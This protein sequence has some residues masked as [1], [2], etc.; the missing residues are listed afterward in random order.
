MIDAGLYFSYVLFFIALGAAI[1]FPL[2]YVIQDPK[3]VIKS[4]VGIV[5]LVVLFIVCYALS[6]NEVTAKYASLGVGEASSKLIG[7]VLIMFYLT[8][9]ISIVGIIF[10]EISK[11]LK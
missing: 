8:L 9:L 5:G 1:I 2:L 11:A 4:L 7:A 3:G 6:G 10:S